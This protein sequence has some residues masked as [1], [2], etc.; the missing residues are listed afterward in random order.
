V[1]GSQCEWGKVLVWD[2]PRRLVLAWQINGQW[3][4]DPAFVT[5]VEV[6]FTADGPTH[7][8]LEFTHRNLDRFGADG[9]AI[10]QAFESPKGWA[11]ILERFARLATDPQPWGTSAS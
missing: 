3:Q 9:E 8:L 11:G 1:D 4:Y 5:E 7:T 6:K 2:P 10:R